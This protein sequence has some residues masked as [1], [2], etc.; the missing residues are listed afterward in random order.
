MI[1]T[2]MLHAGLALAAAVVV[3]DLMDRDIL[4]RS[5]SYMSQLLLWLYFLSKGV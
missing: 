1:A 3:V 4:A 2:F 5:L